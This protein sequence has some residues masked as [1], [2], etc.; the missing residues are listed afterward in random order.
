VLVVDSRLRHQLHSPGKI[1]FAEEKREIGYRELFVRAENISTVLTHHGVRPGD[2]VALLLPRGIDAACAIYGTL[3]AG[4]CYAPLDIGNPESRLSY[5]IGDLQPACIIGAGARPQWCEA[6]SIPWL[7]INDS[8][9]F[10]ASPH[11]DADVVYR[12]GPEELAAILYTSGSTGNPKGV[13]ISC[14]AVDAFVSWASETFHLTAE[15]SIASLAP[16]H[17]DLSLFDLFAT[18][19]NGGSCRFVPQTL[20]LAPGKLVNWLEENAIT[21][22]YTVPSILS[23]LS[24]RGGLDPERL[25]A[26]KRILFAGEVFPLPGLTRLAKALPHV[27]LYN[28]FGPTETNVCTF[29]QVARDRLESIGELPIGESACAAE[30]SLAASGELRVKGPCVMSGYWQDGSLQELGDEWFSTGDRVSYNDRG[31]LLYHGRMDRMIKAS[32]Y[33]IEPAEIESV[34]NGFASVLG[35]V[36]FGEPDPICGNRIVAAVAGEHIDVEGLRSHLKSNLA[37]YMQP[38][39][40]EQ[41]DALPRLSNGKID[42]KAVEAMI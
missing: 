35:S 25:P 32:G 21:G 10:A 28:L 27:E 4:A 36:V 16:F 17:F 12:A 39:R 18:V 3:F 29:W 23:F 14:R 7:D 22:W 40:L 26:M 19:H 9:L 37:P 41:I 2:R 13:C 30:L 6:Q 1:A 42:L 20:T 31:E 8:E 33:R 24:M 11:S 15:D 38:Y 34:I 5:I